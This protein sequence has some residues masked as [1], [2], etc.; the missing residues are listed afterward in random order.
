MPINWWGSPGACLPPKSPLLAMA[1][2]ADLRRGSARCSTVGSVVAGRKLSSGARLRR[3]G[4]A[5][6][7]VI[8]PQDSCRAPAFQHRR[9]F[10]C[11]RDPGE[12]VPIVKAGMSLRDGSL[13]VNNLLLKSLITSAYGVREV[14]IFGL[15]GWAEKARYDIRAKVT[16][17]D[18]K[19]MDGISREQRRALMAAMLEDRFHLRLHAVTKNLPVYDLTVARGGPRFSES[20]RPGVEP[21]LEIWED[22]VQ[23]NGRFDP[24]TVLFFGRSCR[25][26]SDR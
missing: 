3:R 9:P 11:R 8:S 7:H 25:A 26:H 19:V 4:G 23:R 5:P 22:G 17:A 20:V 15:P 14:L 18:P 24:G 16:D 6:R 21:H 1:N 12:Q 10:R 13:Q 2:H